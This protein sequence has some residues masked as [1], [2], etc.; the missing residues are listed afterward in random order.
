MD[1][2]A[3]QGAPSQS[4]QYSSCTK[5]LWAS[6]QKPALLVASIERQMCFKSVPPMGK[7]RGILKTEIYQIF[8][9]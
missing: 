3:V 7:P 9:V 4:L 6:L 1:E 2:Y 8:T 5:L